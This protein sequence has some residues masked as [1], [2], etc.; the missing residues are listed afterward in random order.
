MSL[1]ANAT[2]ALW[3]SDGFTDSSTRQLSW[4][5]L[6]I[7]EIWCSH[8]LHSISPLFMR[9]TVIQRGGGL[10]YMSGPCING[11][12]QDLIYYPAVYVACY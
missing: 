3:N 12:L 10:Q 5:S 2:S 1:C 6:C 9:K 4:C 11:K 7:T 8:R